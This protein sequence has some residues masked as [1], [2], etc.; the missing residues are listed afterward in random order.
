MAAGLRAQNNLNLENWQSITGTESPTDWVTYNSFKD[1]S[2]TD[3]ASVKKA[4]PAYSGQFAAKIRPVLI[5]F[6]FQYWLPG[7]MYQMYASTAKPKSFRFAYKYASTVSGDPA[8]AAV[9]FY[10]GGT[11]D[12]NNIVG[13]AIVWLNPSSSYTY[14]NKEITWN[15]AN[16]PDTGYISFNTGPMDT[17]SLLTIDDVSLSSFSA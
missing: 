15:N 3:S 13:Q 17:A 10:K 2:L 14:V 1:F 5:D 9:Y 16:T 12:T 8:L 6:G 7:T 4:K 11:A